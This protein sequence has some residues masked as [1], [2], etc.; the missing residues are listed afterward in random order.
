MYHQI[1]SLLMWLAISMLLG[2]QKQPAVRQ[3]NYITCQEI[4]LL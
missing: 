1:N 3:M 2:N 4:C